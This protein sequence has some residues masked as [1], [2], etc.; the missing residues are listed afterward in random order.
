MYRNRPSGAKFIHCLTAEAIRVMLL[1]FSCM[2][3]WLEFREIEHTF[4]VARRKA[5]VAILKL[6]QVVCWIRDGID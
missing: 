4:L 2:H 5:V 3:M 6:V 1:V